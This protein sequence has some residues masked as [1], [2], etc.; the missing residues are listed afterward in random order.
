MKYRLDMERNWD[1][2]L[3]YPN[4]EFNYCFP[5]LGICV[6][7][8][9]NPIPLAATCM[10]AACSMNAAF[11]ATFTGSLFSTLLLDFVR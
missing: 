1:L 5:V 2:L 6:F 4:S 9:G 11:Q 3:S 7:V 10:P 8:F